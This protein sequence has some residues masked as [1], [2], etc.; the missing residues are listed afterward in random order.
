MQ[1]FTLTI[2]GFRY[3]LLGVLVTVHCWQMM[4]MRFLAFP[5]DHWCA[6]PVGAED[7]GMNVEFWRNIS[8]PINENGDFD[9]CS[10]YDV[11]LYDSE[12]TVGS[13]A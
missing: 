6:R 4:V 13:D 2:H 1:L 12:E 11:G 8:A 10:M 7:A 5:V 9:K 3:L